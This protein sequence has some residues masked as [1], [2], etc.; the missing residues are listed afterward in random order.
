MTNKVKVI[1]FNV[2]GLRSR[3]NQLSEVL[4]QHQPDIIGLQETKVSNE[5]FPFKDIE[6][7]GYKA[8]I[9]GQKGHYGVAFLTKISA[10]KIQCGFPLMTSEQPKRM[11]H[12][13]FEV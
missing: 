4:E 13:E 11:I 6:H 8:H 3:I 12:G 9:H 5:E 1:S 10:S 7:L 2:N